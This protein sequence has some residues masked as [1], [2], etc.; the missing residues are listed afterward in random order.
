MHGG[1]GE[2]KRHFVYHFAHNNFQFLVKFYSDPKT[3]GDTV[4]QTDDVWRHFQSVC[5]TGVTN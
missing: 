3:L 4:A 1:T 2:Y 5:C